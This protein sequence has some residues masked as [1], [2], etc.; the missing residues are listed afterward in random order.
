MY[1]LQLYMIPMSLDAADGGCVL[2]DMFDD[3]V[4]AERSAINVTPHLVRMSVG[5]A[6]SLLRF[7]S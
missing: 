2:R 5:P 7:E 1:V 3:Y 6:G 4:L